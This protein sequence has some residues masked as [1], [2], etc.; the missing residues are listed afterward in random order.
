VRNEVAI[1][2]G[3]KLIYETLHKKRLPRPDTAGARND[4]VIPESIERCDPAG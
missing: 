4:R 1:A 3:K 2:T